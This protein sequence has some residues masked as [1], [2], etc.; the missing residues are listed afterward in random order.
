MKNSNHIRQGKFRGRQVLTSIGIGSLLGFVFIF[1]W[2][3]VD[4]MIGD[5]PGQSADYLMAKADTSNV[6][7]YLIGNPDN[8]P[9]IS[10]EKTQKMKTPMVLPKNIVNKNITYTTC[11]GVNTN[12][13]SKKFIITPAYENINYT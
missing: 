5:L 10:E 6:I 13:M 4:G 7:I 1:L 11:K 3:P 9:I 8:C 2:H 12:I